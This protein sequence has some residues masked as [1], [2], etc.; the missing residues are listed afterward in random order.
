MW[1]AFV[2][3][4]HAPSFTCVAPIDRLSLVRT[5]RFFDSDFLTFSFFFRT[6]LGPLIPRTDCG[7]TRSRGNWKKHFFFSFGFVTRNYAFSLVFRVIIKTER[8]FF[9]FN[10]KQKKKYL[11]ET[12]P[13]R[14][15]EI[16]PQIS[17]EKILFSRLLFFQFLVYDLFGIVLLRV[18]AL[19]R[20]MITFVLSPRGVDI[21]ENPLSSETRSVPLWCSATVFLF[22]S[23]LGVRRRSYSD[24]WTSTVCA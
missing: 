23:F 21:V 4:N 8:W 13:C 7:N 15:R 16:A 3:T 2:R 10:C 20:R 9:S 11:Y 19:R 1:Y 5:T 6:A 12:R 18:C 14:R 24:E 17:T 22:F